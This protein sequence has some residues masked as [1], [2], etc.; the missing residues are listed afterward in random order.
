VGW[1]AARK[2]WA[3]ARGHTSELLKNVKKSSKEADLPGRFKK[4]RQLALD[5]WKRTKPSQKLLSCI[6]AL[7]LLLA[8]CRP[9]HPPVSTPSQLATPAPTLQ[10]LPDEEARLQMLAD[11]SPSVVYVTG[12][13]TPWMPKEVPEG[14]A[15]P[16]GTAWMFDRRHVVTSL[17]NI[18][19][20]QRGSLRVIFE[21]R[22]ELP[23]R[24]VGTDPGSDLAVLEI[25]WP[26]RSA[27][28]PRQRPPGLTLGA[29]SSLQLGQDVTVVGRKPALDMSVSRGVVYGLGQ[30]LVLNSDRPVQSSIQ[31]DAVIQASN[32]GGPLLNSRGQVIGMAIGPLEE[33]RISQAIP[34]DSLRKYVQSI[35]DNGHVSRP[36]LG[37]YLEPDGFAER[38]GAHGVVVQEVLPGPAR[39]AGLK[40]GDIIIFQ[41]DVAIRRMD[42]L[43]TALE[44]YHPGDGFQ[45]RV[46]RQTAGEGL[47]AAFST[48]SY[49]TVDLR[50][51]LGTS[52]SDYTSR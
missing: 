41:G 22:T 2:G 26:K 39:K 46:L 31:T 28:A 37:I 44:M 24:V 43:V 21:D 10:L 27:D 52:D 42:D 23:A 35:L 5:R 47:G 16:G 48:G 18:D 13:P 12:K 17:S 15:S 49:S 25:L 38:L 34:A 50:V 20:A 36:A 51:V 4:A 8:T 19:L 33:S 30:P 6:L 32:R 45:L 11:T 3:K 29:S 40:A 7:L 14:G 9:T 1:K